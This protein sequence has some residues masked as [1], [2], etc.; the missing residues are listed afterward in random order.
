MPPTRPGIAI[1]PANP[2]P[3]ADLACVVTTASYDLDPVVYQTRW[4]RDGVY[5]KTLGNVARV[6][7]DRTDPG[8]RWRCEVRASDGSERSPPATAEVVIAQ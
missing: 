7:A 1:E 8:A 4:F 6:P 3:N 2:G 5:E